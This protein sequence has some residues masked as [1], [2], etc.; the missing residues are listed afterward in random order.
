VVTNTRR[1][2]LTELELSELI[3]EVHEFSTDRSAN[4]AL[5]IDEIARRLWA[6]QQQG[7]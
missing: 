6:L 4:E 5:S 3:I 7:R 1:A 2:H